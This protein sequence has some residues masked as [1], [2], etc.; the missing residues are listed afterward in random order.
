M[1][2]DTKATNKVIYSWD[3]GLTWEEYEFSNEPIWVRN[4]VIES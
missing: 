4:I 2:K 1:A 3:E